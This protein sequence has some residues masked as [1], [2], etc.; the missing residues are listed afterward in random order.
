MRNQEHRVLIVW[1]GG[2]LGFGQPGIAFD[3]V[4]RPGPLAR[5]HAA[6]SNPNGEVTF[7]R[8]T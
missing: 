4:G 1:L 5:A 6:K 8:W 2:E 7:E 3:Q